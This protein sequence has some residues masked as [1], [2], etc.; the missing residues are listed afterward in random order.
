M[1][2]VSIADLRVSQERIEGD[3]GVIRSELAAAKNMQSVNHAQNRKDIHELRDLAQ[4]T[5]DGLYDM[6]IKWARMGGYAAGAGAVVAVI[7]HLIDKLWKP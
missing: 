7:A 5:V 3:M 2:G 4:T 6:K 1:A